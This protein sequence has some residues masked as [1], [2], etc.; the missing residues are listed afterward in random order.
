M[1]CNLPLSFP[2]PHFPLF[3][4]TFFFLLFTLINAY[5]SSQILLLLS[6]PLF[7][8][9]V[10]S[11]TLRFH[12]VLASVQWDGV[13]VCGHPVASLLSE[14]SVFYGVWADVSAVDARR[15]AAV[16]WWCRQRRLPGYQPGGQIC[17][18]QIWLWLWRSY[19]KV[20]NILLSVSIPFLLLLYFLTRWPIL[21][22]MICATGVKS[23]SVWTH[24]M[25]WGCLA[26]QRAVSFRWTASGQWKESLRYFV[27]VLFKATL[28]DFRPQEGR[29]TSQQTQQQSLHTIIIYYYT[30]LCSAGCENNICLITQSAEAKQ[31]VSPTCTWPSAQVLSSNFWERGLGHFDLLDV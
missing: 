7:S 12:T 23:R 15:D 30:L 18:V 9:H 11:P 19:N 24:G 29:K 2:S 27:S 8:F 10:F 3:S 26:Q 14:L 16:Q 17:G 4:S 21:Y 6:L 5:V 13:F 20:Q 22:V 25:S 31:H 1:Q 28:W